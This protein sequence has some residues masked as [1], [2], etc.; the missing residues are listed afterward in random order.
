MKALKMAVI[1][2]VV[3]ITAVALLGVG[4]AVAQAPTAWEVMSRMMAGA[5]AAGGNRFHGLNE[6][7]E[8][9]GGYPRNAAI[10]WFNSVS[11]SIGLL[12]VWL[13]TARISSP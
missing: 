11:T 5:P 9:R 3:A 8:G 7:A 13:T 1:A 6:C 2:G 4:L 10:R 12:T